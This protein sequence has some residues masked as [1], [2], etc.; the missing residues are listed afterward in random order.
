[1]SYLQL[2]GEESKRLDNH[3]DKV[4]QMAVLDTGNFDLEIRETNLHDIIKKV[5]ASCDILLK[6]QGGSL[7]LELNADTPIMKADPGHLFNLFYNLLDNAIKYSQSAPQIHISTSNET[8]GF[9]FR[10]K[11]NGIGI[12]NE[13]RRNIFE[14]FYRV[15]VG[16]VHKVKGF[17]LGLSYV[18]TIVDAHRGKIS[19]KSVMNQ[20][21]E[22][23]IL[24][25]SF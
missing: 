6:E 3:V 25:P 5:V 12:D 18:K 11:D 19:L 22:F 13:A 2:I 16:D 15:S 8:E 9:C 4:L 1:M 7:Q 21:S 17:G 14:K 20:G 24:L 23:T 10:I